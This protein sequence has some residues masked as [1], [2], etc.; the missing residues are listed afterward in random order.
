[1]LSVNRI[2]ERFS[3]NTLKMKDT[4]KFAILEVS[5]V[6]RV[7]LTIM[8]SSLTVFGASPGAAFFHL[9]L[10]TV[11]AINKRKVLS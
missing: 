11:A 1:M 4:R 9:C 10:N 8:A 3:F 6:D 5:F 2:L 7:I